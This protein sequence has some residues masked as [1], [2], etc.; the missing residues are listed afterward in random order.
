MIIIIYRLMIYVIYSWRIN[1]EFKGAW[2][3]PRVSRKQ[4]E[5]NLEEITAASARLFRQRGLDGV[6]VAELMAAAGLTHGGFY[7]HFQSKDILA[8]IACT[9]SFDQ[10]RG[11][12]SARVEAADSNS[13]ALAAIISGYLDSSRRDDPGPDCAAATL[14]VDVARQPADRPIHRAFNAGIETLTAMLAG[15]F[16]KTREDGRRQALTTFA[17]MVGGIALARATRGSAISD[18]IL[19]AVRGSLLASV[20]PSSRAVRRRSPQTRE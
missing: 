9:R 14:V 6:S 2:K 4:T 19:E 7:N 20:E 1:P 10:T 15:L 8:A 3:M 16:A 13:A 18:E 12:W 5:M 11:R 17:T